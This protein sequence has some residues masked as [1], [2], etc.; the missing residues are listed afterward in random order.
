MRIAFIVD[1]FPALSQTFVL[2]QITGLLDRGQQVDIFAYSP[3]RDPVRH[4]DVEKYGLL[5]R[6]YYLTDCACS[7]PAPTRLIKRIG[8]LVKNS[9]K[10]PFTVPKTLNVFKFGKGALFLQVLCQISPFFGKR[11]YEIVHCQFGD[12]GALGL[13]LRDT[14]LFNGRLVTSFRGYDSSSYVK[15]HGADVYDDLFRRGDLFLCVSEHIKNKL[16]GLGCDERKIVVHR[17]G[18]ETKNHRWQ[19]RDIRANGLVRILTV[20][21]LTEKKG[22]EYGIR[23]V[24]QVI[25]NFPRLEYIIAGDGPLKEKL[26]LIIDELRVGDNVRLV[27]CKSQDEIATLMKDSDIL[28]APSVTSELGDEEGIPGVIMEAFAYGLPVVS[29]L[30]AGIPEVVKDGVSGFLLTERDVNALAEKLL[31]LVKQP[32]MRT[33]MGSEGYEFVVNHCDVA[34]LND[35]LLETYQKLVSKNVALGDLHAYAVGHSAS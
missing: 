27:G 23:A 15:S 5:S 3:G 22:V 25:Q 13:L 1:Q 34:T 21:R 14:G 11:P 6:T 8:L 28:L 19:R 2:R 26:Q 17:S 10:Y 30:H 7:D 35:R 18:V 32:G 31:L 29:T 24:G 9:H 4:Q 12:L 33:S 20:A 16:I